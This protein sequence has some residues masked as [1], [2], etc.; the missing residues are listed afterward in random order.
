MTAFDDRLKNAQQTILTQGIGRCSESDL[1]CLISRPIIRNWGDNSVIAL[2][3]MMKFL[4]ETNT[5]HGPIY[6]FK[7][8]I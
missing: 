2:K 5:F 1:L 4:S 3:I 8:T 6:N 7:G